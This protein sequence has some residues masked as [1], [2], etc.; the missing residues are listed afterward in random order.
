MKSDSKRYQEAGVDINAGYRAVELMKES[1]ARTMIPG[2][3]SGLGGWRPVRRI[4]PASKSRCWFPAPT[5]GHQLKLAFLMDRHD[6][7]GIDCVAMCVNDV[8][9]AGARPVFLD[10]IAVGKNV[11]EKVAAIVAG[12]AEGCVQACC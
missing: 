9:C 2:V 10:Y 8:I 5:G 6:S 12:V 1:V 4:C 3:V 11:P 7:I